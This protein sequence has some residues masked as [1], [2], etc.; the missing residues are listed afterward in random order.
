MQLPDGGIR[1]GV[2]SS[3][4]PNE[5]STSWQ[6]SLTVLAYAPDH[7]SGYLYAGVA[8]RAAVVLKML[9]RNELAQVWEKSAVKAMEWSE[10]EYERWKN[11][12]DY[13]K[14]TNR[15]KNA[16]PAERNLAAVEVYR[17][18]QNK[19]WHEV[20]LA[21]QNLKSNRSE[22]TFI[23]ARLDPTLVDKTYKRSRRSLDN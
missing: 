3:E 23:Y 5:G 17:L 19:R 8:A 14:V 9:D 12:P 21:T 18:T 10:A 15:A 13:E 11:S 20:Y 22:A 16:V 7:W 4:H 1:G 2:E 6:E